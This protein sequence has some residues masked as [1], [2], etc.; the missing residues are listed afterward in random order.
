MARRKSGRGT[1]AGSPKKIIT[2]MAAD[3]KRMVSV[4]KRGET[5]LG[6]LFAD[7]QEDIE[8]MQTQLRD[9]QRE[10]PT[11]A[12]DAGRGTPTRRTAA[13]IRAAA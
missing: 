4:V 2:G 11:A 10:I 5:Q 13:D 1:S 7:W 3:L 9:L 8:R 12:R 6:Q